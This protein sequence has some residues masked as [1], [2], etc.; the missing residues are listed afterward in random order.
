MSNQTQREHSYQSFSGSDIVATFNDTVVGEL[1]SITW[2]VTREKAPN[3]TMGFVNP[4]GFA[5]G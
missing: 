2:S 5:R 1:L 3:Y 4:R